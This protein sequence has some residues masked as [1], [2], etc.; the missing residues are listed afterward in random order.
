MPIL[1]LLVVASNL[2]TISPAAEPSRSSIAPVPW[3]IDSENES[4]MFAVCATPVAPSRSEKAAVVGEVVSR[5]KTGV[6]VMRA[7]MG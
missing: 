5:L 1:L 3:R 6:P 7:F 4:V 2:S